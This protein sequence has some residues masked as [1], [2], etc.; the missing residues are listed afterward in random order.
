MGFALEWGR[1][2]G[3]TLQIGAPTLDLSIES[4]LARPKL[5]SEAHKLSVRAQIDNHLR[6]WLK[7]PLDEITK[8]MVVERH[9]SMAATPPAANHTLKYFRT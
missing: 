2:T 1:G 4:Y 5:W 6:D 3:K 7:L 9:R 8:V